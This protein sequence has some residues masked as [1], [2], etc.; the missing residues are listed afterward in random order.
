[1]KT[2]IKNYWI[3]ALLIIISHVASGQIKISGKVSGIKGELVEFAGILLKSTGEGTKSDS[4]GNFSLSTSAKGDQLFI[5]SSVGYKAL[6]KEVFLADSDI[7]LNITLQINANTINEVVISAG[8]FEA[9]DKAKGAS[10]TPMDAVTVAG[11]NADITQALRALPGSQ[12]I[13]EQEGLFV[14]GGTGEE[15]KQFIDGTLL[16]N[17]SYPSVP[18]IQQYAR[19]N[20]FLFK[21][22]LF[23][24][25]GYSAL[26]G[27]AMS[28]A[29]ILESVD[30]PE[31]SSAGFFLFPANTGTGFQH[32]A[33]NKRSSYGIN[34]NYSNQSF[35]NSI[36]PQKPDYFSGPEYLQGDVNFRVKTG[37]TGMLKFY[38]NWSQSDVGLNNPDID[39]TTLRSNFRVVGKN[40]YNNLSF[41]DFIN[42]SWKIDLGVAYSYNRNNTVNRLI[43]NTGE[44]VSLPGEQFSF[45][46]NSSRIESDFVQAR[47]LITRLLSNNQ[48]LRFGAEHFYI[49]DRGIING[50]PQ[51]LTDNLTAAFAEGDVSI[52]NNLAAK[53]GAR[54]EYS[55]L[56]NKAFIAPRVGLAYRLNDGSQFNLACGIFYQQQQ[57][58]FLYQKRDIGFSNAAHYV[59]NYTKKASNRFFRAE[60]YYKKYNN[61]VK[62]NLQLSTN[63][64]GYA[65]GFELF[66]RD[67]KTFKNLDYWVTYTYLDT[68]RDFLNYPYELK[69]S[70]TAPHTATVAIK[71]FFQDISTNVNLSYS[72]ASGRP[73]YDIRYNNTGSNTQIFD[74]GTTKAYSV[75]NLHVAYL[76][77]F[78]KNWKR[79][80]FAGIAFGINNLLGTKQV[81]GYNYSFDGS[82]KVQVTLPAKRNYFIGIFMSFGIDRTDDFLDN[83]Q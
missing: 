59:L 54:L 49:K 64:E 14:R 57:N 20:P 72:L 83:I 32:V 52:A 76:T 55:G 61:L 65:Q 38:S 4:A 81:F 45:K 34:L 27:Q 73:Y 30:L 46:N 19:I 26:Y 3:T 80:D 41:R 39:S 77:S 43:N 5:I 29:L 71:K 79:K 16:K 53:L 68:K 63:G 33:K 56:Q 47:F 69:P 40:V 82:N 9:S 37:K 1:M 12:Q 36:V 8:S 50:N 78:F 70:F 6:K 10:L 21:G 15:T 2:T 24:S 22:I 18:G 48:A 75:M 13:G 67:K 62:N 60:A 28:S 25:G 35:Y 58:I 42:D 66:W 51:V 31:K 44:E 23:N 7:H 11:S 17:P 74:Q